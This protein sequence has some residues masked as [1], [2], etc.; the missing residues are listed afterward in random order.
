MECSP[1]EAIVRLGVKP[2]FATDAVGANMDAPQG[3]RVVRE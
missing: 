2:D 1:A 3:I